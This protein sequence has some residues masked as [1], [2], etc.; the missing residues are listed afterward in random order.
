MT[1]AP[2]FAQSHMDL[3]LPNTKKPIPVELK[4]I[5]EMYGSS[6][7]QKG[8]GKLL[9]K[10]CGV[11]EMGRVA[12]EKYCKSLEFPLV[13][14]TGTSVPLGR[15]QSWF[16]LIEKG[17]SLAEDEGDSVLLDLLKKFG[18]EEI[19]FVNI[20]SSDGGYDPTVVYEALFSQQVK[21][22]IQK[23][24]VRFSYPMHDTEAL[25]ALAIVPKEVLSRLSVPGG[26]LTVAVE[27]ES[28]F[29]YY[30]FEDR[31]VGEEEIRVHVREIKNKDMVD[32]K[33]MGENWVHLHVLVFPKE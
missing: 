27:N 7:K 31:G 8:F 6:L 14:M 18:I 9:E 23:V 24:K 30:F 1:P 3:S 29:R 16:G 17:V 26:K 5:G 33:V 20:V 19:K 25:A 2:E 12:L 10:D 11:S 13:Y 21:G 28:G 15:E 22:K 4:V 32:T